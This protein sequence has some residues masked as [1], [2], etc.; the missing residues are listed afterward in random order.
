MSLQDALD[1][2]EVTPMKIV[3]TPTLCVDGSLSA[4]EIATLRAQGWRIA[5]HDENGN[6][7]EV[8]E[9]TSA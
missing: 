7:I 9:R 6:L 3:G 8:L 5:R 1:R 2:I 4:D